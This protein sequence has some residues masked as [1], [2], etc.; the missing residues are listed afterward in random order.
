MTWQALV[1]G[2]VRIAMSFESL[3]ILFD[4]IPVFDWASINGFEGNFL[5]VC[6][7]ENVTR[8]LSRSIR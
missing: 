3:S 5:D 2:G 8:V 6:P 7:K 4:S 1:L